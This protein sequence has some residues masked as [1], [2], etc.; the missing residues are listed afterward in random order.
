MRKS[1]PCQQRCSSAE[2]LFS[3]RI[4]LI[5]FEMLIELDDRVHRAPHQPAK[6]LLALPHLRFCPHAAQFG[7]R[8]RGENL[9]K[10]L[11]P[12]LGRHWPQVEN[13]QMA[14]NLAVHIEQWHAHVTR[15]T[16]GFDIR[17][18]TVNIE[19]IIRNMDKAALVYDSLTGGSV[20]HHLPV[21]EPLTAHPERQRL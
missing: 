12:G 8:A 20:D 10:S 11:R 17:V 5:D 18:F 14:K 15:R 9:K 4:D 19:E 16:H 3:R 13:R 7:G 6:L 1:L 21:F 2:N